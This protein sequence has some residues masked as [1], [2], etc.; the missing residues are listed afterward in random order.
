MKFRNDYGVFVCTHV[1]EKT[2][3]V[4]FSVRDFDGDWQFLCGI[5]GCVESGRPHHIGVGHLVAED[6]TIN[7]LTALEPGTCARR[8]ALGSQWVVGKLEE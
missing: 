6:A 3:P 5:D 1:F 2:R 4:L 7:D 8:S